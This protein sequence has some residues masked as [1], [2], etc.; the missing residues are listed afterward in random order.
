M[1]YLRQLCLAVGLILAFAFSTYAGDMP[2]PAA[3]SVPT[4][5]ATGEMPYP[6]T[7]SLD[8]VTEITLNFVRSVLLLF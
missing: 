7:A 2:C 4:L 3:T 8:P 1:K 5:S 6:V